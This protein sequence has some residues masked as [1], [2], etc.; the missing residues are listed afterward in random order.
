MSCVFRTQSACCI[1]ASNMDAGN[2]DDENAKGSLDPFR[3]VSSWW[4]FTCVLGLRVT[5]V[6]RWAAACPFVPKQS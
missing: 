3:K 1:A 4:F 5:C 2:M 6:P